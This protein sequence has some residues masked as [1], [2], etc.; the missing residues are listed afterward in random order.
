MNQTRPK[1]KYKPASPAEKKLQELRLN[2]RIQLGKAKGAEAMKKKSGGQ[3]REPSSGPYRGPVPEELI[4]ARVPKTHNGEAVLNAA[5][6]R[7]KGNDT[8][9]PPLNTAFPCPSRLSDEQR[10]EIFNRLRKKARGFS[11]LDK[12]GS[13]LFYIVTGESPRQD[14]VAATLLTL[15]DLYLHQPCFAQDFRP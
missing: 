13:P 2:I 11:G 1:I 4:A 15:A 12:Q 14:Y 3:P 10:A 9:P 7:A 5:I 8:P 6:A